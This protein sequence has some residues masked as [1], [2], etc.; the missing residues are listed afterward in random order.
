MALEGVSNYHIAKWLENEKIPTPRVYLM[1]EFG[2]YQMNSLV[3]HPYAWTKGTVTVILS[4]PIYLG[5]L[6]S[7]RY[8][9]RSFKD[10]RIIPRPEEEW[11]TV[12][13]THQALVDQET[14]DLVQADLCEAACD[15][16]GI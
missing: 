2:K 10:K 3:K 9:T 1:D 12:E 11:I 16:G 6:V 13:N 14:F 5:K 8:Q 15:L 4:N 7:L